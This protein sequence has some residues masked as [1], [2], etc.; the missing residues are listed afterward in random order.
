MNRVARFQS[1]AQGEP[2]MTATS[3]SDT[4]SASQ[5]DSGEEEDGR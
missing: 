4:Q 5:K 2:T 1:A 3:L